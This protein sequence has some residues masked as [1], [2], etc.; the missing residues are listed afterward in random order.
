MV[1]I[2]AL[3]LGSLYL[4][5]VATGD[6]AQF[7]RLYSMLFLINIT[8]L[9]VLVWLI[10]SNL[11]RLL[12][13]YR[14]GVMG[15]RLTVRLVVVFVLLALAPVTVVYYFSL[16][17]LHRGIDSWF[18]VKIEQG[19][20]DA[21]ELSRTALDTR[22]K[23][24]LSQTGA[25]AIS[26]SSVPR[27]QLALKLNDLRDE[28]EASE[29]TL[30][31]PSGHIIASSSLDSTR[32]VPNLPNATILSQLRQGHSYAALDTISD[33]GLYVRVVVNAENADPIAEPLVL[34]S[35]FPI[36][37]R[38]S[39]LADSVQGAYADYEQ[40]TYMR[41]P[42][43]FSFTVTLSLV[44]LLSLLTAV[45]AAFYAA[46]R[47]VAPIRVLAVGTRAVAAGDYDQRLPLVSNDEL[48]FLVQSFNEMTR[49]VGLARD[50]VERSKAQTESQRAYLEAVVGRLSSGVLTLSRD[51]ILRTAN[52]AAS[53]ILGVDM[54]DCLAGSLKNIAEL[55]PDVAPFLESIGRHLIGEAQE[56]RE[57]ITLFGPSGRQVLMCRGAPL[58]DVGDMTAGHVIVF[59]DVTTL[60]QA[61]RDAAWGEVARRLAHEIKNPL[62]PI[63]LSAERLRHKYL[64]T[65]NEEDAEVL[66]RSTHTIVQQVEVMK[67]M[68]KAFSEYARAPQLKLDALD[69]NR[70]VSEVLDLYR[71]EGAHVPID[72]KLDP[73][74]PAVRADAGRLRQLL[75]NL[76]KNSIEAVDDAKDG[77]ITVTTRRLIDDDV[78][79][80][81]L[82][83][84]DT[85]PGFAQALAGQMFEPYVTTKPRGS[86]L[87]LAIVK[88]I[89]E[90]HGG[91]V[92]AQS[93]PTGGARITVRL[94]HGGTD[95]NDEN[96]E[97][98][99]AAGNGSR[100]TQH[101]LQIKQ[102]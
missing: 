83:V 84:E 45:W 28:S 47:L 40:L 42:L 9:I 78:K 57:E 79:I 97:S 90:E 92:L 88:K 85:G 44:L 61:Q 13:Q 64:D 65:M 66:D 22:I 75:H 34:Q 49:K 37:Q 73:R 52:A 8:G 46:R 72:A 53:L 1:L 24:L 14:S 63:Q 7:G 67:E 81:E 4:M 89:V 20:N 16:Q 102:S 56:W 27:S 21:L 17:F 26:L 99:A 2:V 39:T 86:G 71:N 74:L 69:L 59:D 6:S 35:L 29:L 93:L 36:A 96:S 58:P 15:S 30:L 68:V 77:K 100:W 10:V 76:I 95:A 25:M 54:Q 33:S 12:R 62:T 3:M 82:C 51:G 5:S 48:G 32:I 101:A 19:L 55:N 31:T 23:E 87:G 41:G 80:A 11:Q 50:E 98:G 60:V 70:I 91:V 38:L 18:D 43:K 94:P